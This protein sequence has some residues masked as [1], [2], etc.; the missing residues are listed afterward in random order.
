MTA[1]ISTLEANKISSSHIPAEGARKYASA[2]RASLESE[3][4]TVKRAPMD[5]ARYA[6]GVI[7][8]ENFRALARVLATD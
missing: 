2:R 8:A 6:V 4:F 1:N 7:E 5:Q 3:L